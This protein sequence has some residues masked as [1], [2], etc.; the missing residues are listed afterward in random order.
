MEHQYGYPDNFDDGGYMSEDQDPADKISDWHG[1][2]SR[3][4]LSVNRGLSI[5]GHRMPSG[6]DGEKDRIPNLVPPGHRTFHDRERFENNTDDALDR[7][8]G[9][10]TKIPIGVPETR[11][12][13]PLDKLE[14]RLRTFASAA[15][16]VRTSGAR[17]RDTVDCANVKAA[18][19]IHDRECTHHV[20]RWIEIRRCIQDQLNSFPEHFALA[21]IGR[22]FDS[23]AKIWNSILS[24]SNNGTVSYVLPP[25][26]GRHYVPAGET[27]LSDVPIYHDPAFERVDTLSKFRRAQFANALK[28]V[29]AY[30]IMITPEAG[31]RI[32]DQVQ[33]N[34]ISWLNCNIELLMG[35]KFVGDSLAQINRRHHHHEDMWCNFILQVHHQTFSDTNHY[36]RANPECYTDRWRYM[37]DG[38]SYSDGIRTDHDSEDPHRF[39]RGPE[40][41]FSWSPLEAKEKDAQDEQNQSFRRFL[42]K[43]SEALKDIARVVHESTQRA[44]ERYRALIDFNRPEAVQFTDQI[45]SKPYTRFNFLVRKYYSKL[46]RVMVKRRL[47]DQLLLYQGHTPSA[48][49]PLTVVDNMVQP[50][51]E[52]FF[53]L[54]RSVGRTHKQIL[55]ELVQYTRKHLTQLGKEYSSNIESDGPVS[56]ELS[57]MDLDWISLANGNEYTSGCFET[58]MHSDFYSNRSHQLAA[59]KLHCHDCEGSSSR[60]SNLRVRSVWYRPFSDHHG[61]PLSGGS[62]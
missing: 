51:S 31:M 8:M 54:E 52:V 2:K 56:L 62:T 59:E 33:C 11:H 57:D 4:L 19:I 50:T 32:Q 23:K 18:L 42:K 3:R 35:E 24:C 38:E 49:H 58:A 7:V 13:L 44:K 47:R 43:N 10:D 1:P 17:Y 9:K 48:R 26:E 40:A 22:E 25:K 45:G 12:Q 16:L 14:R 34:D 30:S 15:T 20:N 27:V 46:T 36:L 37:L 39:W 41:H 60:E 21:R 5:P 6:P 29:I 53:L 55:K 61:R 28:Q